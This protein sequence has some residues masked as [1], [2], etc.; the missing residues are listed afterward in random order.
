MEINGRRIGPGYPPYCIAEISANHAGDLR[1]AIQ[2]IKAAKRAGADAVK[3]QCY[4]ADS[5]TLDLKKPDF[6]CQS[7]LWQGRQL[8]ELYLTAHTPPHWHRE[9]YN[10]AKAEGI[11]I[12]SSV[13][14]RRGLEVLQALDCPC[15]KIASFELTDI[16][17]I[18]AVAATG[19]PVIISTGLG[20]DA[21]IVEADK[22]SGLKAAFLHCTSEYPGTVEH[23]NLHMM[24]LLPYKLAD[25]PYGRVTGISDH[26]LDSE[27]P[28]AATALGAK[29]IEK[30]LRLDDVESEDAAFSLVPAAFSHMVGA[31]QR[32]WKGMQEQKTNGA[33]RQY[34][35]SLYVVEDI[36]KGEVYTEKNIRAI[37]P[38]F[39]LPPKF[40]PKFLGKKARRDW[41]RG[42]PL[43]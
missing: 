32:V 37:R 31:V 15:Y 28:I 22:A 27:V 4:D 6:I 26:T 23:A 5:M 10:V 41:R 38:G 43:S 29:I 17:L 25:N 8:Y 7:G 9:L 19:K 21:E 24:T 34:R 13:F 12:F 39:G 36:K 1:N 33:G 14:D 35:R 2:L 16:P 40:L 42:D 20:N 18:E 30:H 3:T 11:T